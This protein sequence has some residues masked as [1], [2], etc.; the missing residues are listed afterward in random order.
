MP[1]VFNRLIASDDRKYFLKL[2]TSKK[3]RRFFFTAV[4]KTLKFNQYCVRRRLGLN[5]LL[6]RCSMVDQQ[7]LIFRSWEHQQIAYLLVMMRRIDPSNSGVF[8]DIG[9]YWGLYSMIAAKKWN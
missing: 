8:L 9:S 4:A 7:I 1:S 6:D 3:I 2:Y 5:L